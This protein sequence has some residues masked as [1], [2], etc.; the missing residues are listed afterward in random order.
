MKY[1]KTAPLYQYHSTSG[2]VSFKT[3][4]VLLLTSI[5]L[6]PLLIAIAFN[7]P[8]V[9]GTLET[10]LAQRQIA[11]LKEKYIGVG[12]EIIAR[13]ES[14][15]LL[16][17]IPAVRH[18]IGTCRDCPAQQDPLWRQQL[19]DIIQEWFGPI[20]PISSISLL[21][22]SGKEL[23]KI[24]R[25][26]GG[27]LRKLR[28][29]ELGIVKE[30]A[31]KLKKFKF[32]GPDNT[33][34]CINNRINAND[35]KDHKA[36][37]P[38]V[39]ICC[40]VYDT[41]MNIM[42][43]A[44]ITLNLSPI[45]ENSRFDFIVTGNGDYVYNCTA[46]GKKDIHQPGIAFTHF[47]ELKSLVNSKRPGV[48][49]D[50][51]NRTLAWVPIIM[52]DRVQ[53]TMW[54]GSV[55]D[56]TMI[57]AMKRTLIKRILLIASLIFTLVFLVVWRYSSIA[58]RFR[59]ELIRA[60]R[61]LIE[62]NRPIKL[63]WKR[64]E[65]IK[66][67]GQ[68]INKLSDRYLEIMSER[69][70]AESR[71]AELN[72]RLNMI[73]DNAAEGIIELDAKGRIQFAN[74]AAAKILGIDRDD[75][76]GNDLHFLVHYLS[77][78]D[79]HDAEHQCPFC[80]ALMDGNYHLFTEDIFWLK[81]GK[82]V[83]VE[84]LTAPI[85]DQDNNLTG[86]VMC[87]R[88]LTERKKAEKR[89][90]DLQKQLLHSQKMEAIGTLAGGVAHDFNNLLT[91][92]TGYCELIALNIK[93]NEEALKQVSY[94][95]MAAERASELT[96]QLL[97][98]SRKQQ[99]CKRIVDI[100]EL[101][102]NQEKMLKRLIG[103]DIELTTQLSDREPLN[104]MADPGMIEQVI[105]NIVVNARDAMPNG[106]KIIITTTKVCIPPTEKSI[107]DKGKSGRFIVISVED[108]GSGIAPETLKQIFN[109]FFTTKPVDKGTGLGL[110]VAYGIIEQHNGWINVESESGKG[111]VFSIY[112]PEYMG[113]S[114]NIPPKDQL[115]QLSVSG[116]QRKILILE[117]DLMVRE[118]AR[119]IL[120][121]HDF[122]VI[123]VANIKEAKRIFTKEKDHL[124][125]VIS[126][127]I[128]PDGNGLDFIDWVLEMAPEMAV[129][130]TSGYIDE[131]SH[132]EEIRRRGLM[133][134][135][136]P[137][138]LKDLIAAADAAMRKTNG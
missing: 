92:I 106:G 121:S 128:L 53:H 39:T 14:V 10:I 12:K 58:D 82:T 8:S 33:I 59:D 23:Y 123:T 88:D 138:H 50:H 60:L 17:K 67:L 27:R 129:I 76:I 4:L 26:H 83:N 52:S 93:D 104:T 118:I 137:F 113:E 44:T 65:E 84:Y 37:R 30:A 42:G 81:N 3:L 70:R 36:H 40:P 108:T 19:T 103:E 71:L 75:L 48:I 94:I 11:Q 79:E 133:F 18:I 51:K 32:Q 25:E 68:E 15:R 126:D 22:C 97:A 20:E 24:T 1:I 85:Y 72:Q 87:I 131:S 119:E 35:D 61:S 124:D 63:R 64:P 5:G 21:D 34:L 116:R 31:S 78:K 135:E 101:V 46:S 56:S 43:L 13:S 45:L 47:P 122:N 96:R 9:L 16:A 102:R 62:K 90:A 110:S 7:L 54:S 55:V 95:S 109:P 120:E 77:E 130:L 136:K 111:T 73:L 105:M 6:L 86:L 74:P 89:A 100:N 2:A 98:F 99:A 125:L 117:D 49:T 134:T 41:R 66:E 115:G 38:E 91:A 28:E 107:Y 127:V 132:V 80:T 112:L 69:K 114:V 29:Q 57:T